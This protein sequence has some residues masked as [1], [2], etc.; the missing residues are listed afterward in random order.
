M[1]F[2]CVPVA[3][4]AQA[5]SS[6]TAPVT[7]ATVNIYGAKI[8]SQKD[9]TFT[10]SFRL[11]NRQGA[12][13][14]VRYAAELLDATGTVVDEDVYPDVLNL[15]AG[16]SLPLTMAYT[17]PSYLSGTYQLV[18]LSA[19]GS[20]LPLARASL[21][22]VTL[23]GGGSFVE[24]IPSTCYLQIAGGASRQEYSLDQ[25][26]DIAASETLQISCAVKNNSGSDLSL[27]PSFETFYRTA[28]GNQVAAAGV[29]QTPI[30]I[31]AD[32]QKTVTLAL[33]KAATP[34][35]YDVEVSFTDA[36]GIPSNSVIA[37]YVL[38]GASATIQNLT[39]DAT[40]YRAG[41]TAD[42]TLYWTGPAN[43]F[44]DARV[45]PTSLQG[46]QATI[47]IVD[48]S[49][50]TCGAEV[51]APLDAMAPQQVIQFPMSAAC[52]SPAVTVT[53]T[54]A[55]G[56]VLATSTFNFTAPPSAPGVPVS[57]IWIVIGVLGV[58]LIGGYV[59]LRM[60][61]GR[62]APMQALL[63]FVLLG[64]ACSVGALPQQAH[65][66]TFAQ[67]VYLVSAG[68]W[69]GWFTTNFTA[70]LDNDTYLPGA[71]ITASGNTQVGACANSLYADVRATINGQTQEVTSNYHVWGV[72]DYLWET[73]PSPS[74]FTAPV[75]PG[76][77]QASFY[78]EFYTQGTAGRFFCL[79]TGT[80]G[81]TG[82]DPY[83]GFGGSGGSFSDALTSFV[84]AQAY[85][86]PYT[87]VPP[88]PGVCPDG[89]AAPNGNSNQCS[90]SHGNESACINECP[91]GS[92]APGGVASK[93]S[94]AQG[95]AN[96]CKNNTTGTC[97]AGAYSENGSCVYYCDPGYTA[98]GAQCVFVGCSSGYSEQADAQG[99]A[100]CVS[101]GTC[102]GGYICHDGSLYYESAS[103]VVSSSPAEACSYGCS[104]DSCL[105]APPPD[106]A[107]W[108]V[109]PALIKSGGT[110]SVTWQSQN[111][112]SCSVTGS[113]G[114]SWSG[115]SGS[116]ASSPIT[117]QTVYTL[118]CTGL[119]G[120]QISTST[121]V[122]IAPQFQEQ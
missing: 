92:A 78:Y 57:D 115:S 50:N 53:L 73:Q 108:K 88:P 97:P 2:A 28:F 23:S 8:V 122:S 96:A 90:C 22:T 70:N 91:N 72:V 5:A 69:Q 34:Q 119:D 104:G 93:C 59:A 13:P 18:V 101:S 66:D 79:P 105:A 100:E 82:D 24:I 15:A 26:V 75:A 20:G 56:T 98:Q 11:S 49:G 116:E 80:P 31:A 9:G 19:D 58:L 118:A 1:L 33:P 103:C 113:N 110:T 39:L 109:K 67:N 77:Y 36:S 86:I 81:T 94:C 120:T 25:G 12:Q 60:H 41:Q 106:I 62:S 74:A 55:S 35:A 84:A 52:V 16:A 4:L 95:N 83:C 65:A 71:T 121:T 30:A 51:S 112:A 38:D 102:Y 37:H 117:A 45:A 10:I 114:D 32:A 40:S 48:A 43:N 3:A 47:H 7:V 17:P 63:L 27:Q 64:S 76:T 61:K 29:S 87:V 6:G 44:P 14:D 107:N 68:G 46:A 21:G 85:T 111:V 42:A 99:N 89:S 54:D